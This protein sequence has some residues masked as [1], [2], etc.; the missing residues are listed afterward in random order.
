MKIVDHIYDK[1][2]PEHK[3]L[4]HEV[5]KFEEKKEALVRTLARHG[6]ADAFRD[7]EQRLKEL[8]G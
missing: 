2:H 3:Q 6:L 1:L 5:Q 4:E 7:M 8:K